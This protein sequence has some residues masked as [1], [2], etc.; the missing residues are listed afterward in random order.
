M[1]IFTCKKYNPDGS[2]EVKELAANTRK[3][4]AARAKGPMKDVWL[5]VGKR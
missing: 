5:R 1:Q 2:E 4:A 3:E